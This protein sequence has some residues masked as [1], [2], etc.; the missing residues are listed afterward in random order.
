MK[1]EDDD[2]GYLKYANELKKHSW[3]FRIEKFSKFVC[4]FDDQ[5]VNNN[6]YKRI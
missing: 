4:S 2:K 1:I 3:C 6:V 5:T